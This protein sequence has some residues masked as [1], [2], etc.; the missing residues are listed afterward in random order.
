[1]TKSTEKK[2]KIIRGEVVSD[3]MDKTVVINASR[4]KTHNL[5]HKKFTLNKKYKAHDEN[6]EFRIGDIVEIA[7]SKPFSKDKNYIVIN[8]IS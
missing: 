4:I 8:K 3:S 7:P 1:M 6:N 5:Y 2:V